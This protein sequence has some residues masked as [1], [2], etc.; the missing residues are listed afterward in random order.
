M[1]DKG[2][3]GSLAVGL[4][5]LMRLRAWGCIICNLRCK[6]KVR[7]PASP[8]VSRSELGMF[9]TRV[10]EVAR[11]ECRVPL[12]EPSVFSEARGLFSRCE[13]FS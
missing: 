8:H 10:S 9:C 11:V 12:F 3:R 7:N 2:V 6:L 13:F 1:V 5:G 4:R